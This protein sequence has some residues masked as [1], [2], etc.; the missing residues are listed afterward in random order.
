[1]NLIDQ[2]G[3]NPGAAVPFSA[4]ASTEAPRHWLI[5][6]LINEHLDKPQNLDLLTGSSG[7]YLLTAVVPNRSDYECL[8]VACLPLGS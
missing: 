7:C 8:T 4:A 2:V 3:F 6:C 1:L 5:R